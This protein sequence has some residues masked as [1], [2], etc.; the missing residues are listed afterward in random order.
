MTSYADVFFTAAD[1]TRLYLRDYPGPRPD[2]PVVVCLHGLTRNS[3][4]FAELAAHL[5]TKARVLVPDM[6]GR[7]RSARAADTRT[8]QPP[9]YVQ[10]VLGWLDRLGIARVHLVG[11]SMGGIMSLLMLS[12]VPERVQSLVINDI[13][14]ELDAVGV[15]RISG[16]VGHSLRTRDWATAAANIRTSNA[17]AFPDY[18]DADWQDM[19]R[20]LHVQ[21]DSDVVLDYDPAIAQGLADGSAV[22]T[23]WPLWEALA[24]RPLLVL[25]GALSDLLSEATVS[26]MELRGAWVQ[27]AVIAQRGHAPTLNEAD[28][29]AAI[30]AFH[31]VHLK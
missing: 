22:P 17:S 26:R 2:A 13:G 23:L 1:G 12:A 3:K 24:P 29:R 6:R 25:R 4:D 20:R 14:P 27:S 18:S 16:Y 10:D 7:G 15:Q 19:A 8:Y 5:Q 9:H 28:S 31:A 11:T 21:Q 30:D